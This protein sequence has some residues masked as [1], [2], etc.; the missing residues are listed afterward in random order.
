MHIR[1]DTNTTPVVLVC[2]AATI[3]QNDLFVALF[4]S[5]L[6]LAMTSS[7]PEAMSLSL[8]TPTNVLILVEIFGG[9]VRVS[10]SP[11]VHRS[12]RSGLCGTAN[13]RAN[14]RANLRATTGVGA[15]ALQ[16]AR[17]AGAA[18]ARASYL[19][20]DPRRSRAQRVNRRRADT[21]PRQIHALVQ[22]QRHRPRWFQSL[23]AAGSVA[24]WR[25][26]ARGRR[27]RRRL[28]S[29]GFRWRFAARGP[30][31]RHPRCWPR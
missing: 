9:Q 2:I 11:N 10:R 19:A 15:A 23:L 1:G 18:L 27:A 6:F 8:T 26:A 4:E 22:R 29:R 24:R 13:R 28:L 20:H 16:A 25:W 5:S 31:Q 14:R 30:H 7:L 12:S 17:G 21:P 3:L